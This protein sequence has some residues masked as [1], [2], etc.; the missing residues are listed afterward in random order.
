M[1]RSFEPTVKTAITVG[2]VSG[3]PNTPLI[4]TSWGYFCICL[5]ISYIP[6]NTSINI[7]RH[8]ASAVAADLCSVYVSRMLH[9]AR[10]L[11]AMQVEYLYELVVARNNAN[12]GRW[13]DGLIWSMMSP[14]WLCMPACASQPRPQLL[15][16]GVHAPWLAGWPIEPPVCDLWQETGWVIDRVTMDGATVHGISAPLHSIGYTVKKYSSTSTF[17]P[18]L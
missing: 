8:V 16:V 15:P 11:P 18:C 2:S 9:T 12:G 13:W 7:S 3:L 1:Q 10:S 4:W 5:Y 14:A 6:P 17:L